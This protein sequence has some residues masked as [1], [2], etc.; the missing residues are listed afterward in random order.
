M[1]RLNLPNSPLFGVWVAFLAQELQDL[2][3]LA[4]LLSHST[5]IMTLWTLT[6][7]PTP[8]TENFTSVVLIISNAGKKKH[9]KS[10]SNYPFQNA[11][12]NNPDAFEWEVWT[13]NSDEPVLEQALLDMWYGKECC[14]NLS[15]LSNRIG[16]ELCSQ[17]GESHPQWGKVGTNKGKIWWVNEQEEEQMSDTCPGEGWERGRS[18]THAIKVSETLS[19][20]ITGEKHSMSKLTDTQRSE[21]VNRGV[22]GFGGNVKQLA[23]EFNIS[24]RQVRHIINHWKV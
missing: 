10:E 13:D 20:K 6:K 5:V 15:S 17:K 19:G 16:P 9:L 3:P 1:V 4:S 8:L 21:I 12:R 7:Q 18:S 14:Y 2:S 23:T 11:L 24:G 22:L